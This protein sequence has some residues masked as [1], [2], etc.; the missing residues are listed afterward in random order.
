MG[1]PACVIALALLGA[2][3]LQAP[4]SQN[5]SAALEQHLKAAEPH[6]GQLCYVLG[7]YVPDHKVARVTTSSRED[8]DGVE[9][10]DAF[11]DAGL[12]ESPTTH[13]PSKNYPN[14]IDHTYAMTPKG[15]A[16]L[17]ERVVPGM[18]G[19]V[20][21]AYSLCVGQLKV[22]EVVKWTE[23]TPHNGVTQSQ[24]TYR[25]HYADLPS[26][27]SSP[28]VLAK[29]KRLTEKSAGPHEIRATVVLTNL[30]WE[31]IK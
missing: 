15:S 24:V 12:F 21:T 1:L 31:V 3:D 2:S 20:T 28:A 5:F 19:T 10:Y 11:V 22:D 13:R 26:W 4:N 18:P 25:V 7:N 17:Q 27:T 6:D 30:G 14:L 9:L 16:L 29:Y 23:P 8:F